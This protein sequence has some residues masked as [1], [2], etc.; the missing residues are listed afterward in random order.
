MINDKS[1]NVMAILL[2]VGGLFFLV[3]FGIM[4]SLGSSTINWVMD[5]TVP[6]LTGLGQ[7][8][9][10]N[11]TETVDLVITPVNTFIQNFT[12]VSGIVYVFGLIAMFGLAYTFRSTGDKWLIGLFVALVLILVIGCLFMSN[13]YEDFFASSDAMGS[14]M[15]E[16]V[17][18][19][20]M[21]L[22]S[23]GIMSLIAF[24][25]GIILFS[26]PVRDGV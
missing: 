6:E 19:S 13:I 4:L 8:G 17:L 9:S 3:L 22:Y 11:A 14:I 5:E 12:W 10:W 20:W 24:I 15:K 16:H 7:V 2:V 21:I 23:P 1:A 25:A 26:G 18:L